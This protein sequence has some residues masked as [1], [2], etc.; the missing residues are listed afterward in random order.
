[1]TIKLV[2]TT[3]GDVADPL[4]PGDAIQFGVKSSA[5][6]IVPGTLHAELGMTS[7]KHNGLLPDVDPALTALEATVGLASPELASPVTGQAS[8]TISGGSLVLTKV[9]NGARD[10]SIYSIKIPIRQNAS[11]M[12]YMKLRKKTSWQSLNPAWCSLSNMKGA[13]VG[14]EYGPANTGLYAFFRDNGANGSIVIGGPQA[15]PT[16]VRPSQTELTSLDPNVANQGWKLLADNDTLEIWIYVNLFSNPYTVEVW[17]KR[18][19]DVSPQ[20][21]ATLPLG[22]LGT[23]PVVAGLSQNFRTGP[24]NHATLFFGN[25]GLDG[26]VLQI[27]DWAIYPDYRELIDEGEARH[28]A[29]LL[30]QPDAPVVFD[31]SEGEK[32]ES[33]NL[34]RWIQIPDSGAVV[35]TR[36]KYQPGRPS[37]PIYTTLK[38]EGHYAG[39]QKLEPRLEALQDGAMFEAFLAGESSHP[40]GS[41]TGMGIGIEDGTKS[42]KLLFIEDPTIRTVGILKDTS[43]AGSVSGYY[44]IPGLDYT[45]LKLVR[46]VIDR[47]RSEISVYA[48]NMDTP[49]LTLPLSSVVPP[50]TMGGRMVAGFLTNMGVTGDLNIARLNYLARYLA[51]EGRD[52]FLPDS[53]SVNAGVRFTYS[54]SGD[55]GASPGIVSISG[56]VLSIVKNSYNENGSYRFFT[57]AADISEQKGLLVD[58]RVGIP[59]YSDIGGVPNDILTDCGAG[60]R[61]YFGN[62]LLRLGFFDCGLFGKKI[63]IIPGSGSANDIIDQSDLGRAFSASHD[64]TQMTSYRLIVRAYK[65]IEVWTGPLDGEPQ[66][67]IPWRND[68]DGFDL[69]LDGTTPSMQFGHFDGLTSS[70]SKWVYLRWGISNGYEVSVRPSFPDGRPS[71]L[72]NGKVFSLIDVGES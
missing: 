8:G 14:L 5:L 16:Q 40:V 24:D 64:W 46:L 48:E 72:F 66:I 26:D 22:S 61:F 13:Y 20:V 41:G 21:L 15:G 65:S 67:V 37:R 45:S 60:L 57:R 10:A 39:L 2:N 3:P 23:F 43:L 49:A 52:N 44:T 19:T 29:T 33:L 17:S 50:S 18:S 53:G 70:N 32:L 12:A 30:M 28:N 59:S 68:T 35:A 58:F 63:G 25:S 34:G 42:W 62:K 6:S 54:A 4:A 51:W 27:D 7:V 69:P 1:V 71:Y 36:W 56:G 47:R 55:G 31:A 38:G 9:G 11:V